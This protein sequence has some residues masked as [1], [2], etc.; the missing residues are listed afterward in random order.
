[1][2]PR[3]LDSAKLQRFRSHMLGVLNAG[4]TA[5]MTSIGHRAGLFDVMSRMRAATSREI[6]IAAGLDER[7]VREWLAA[8]VTGGVVEYGAVEQTYLLPREHAAWLTRRE[9][10]DNLAALCQWIPALGAIEDRVL[11]C[12]ERGGGVPRT[13]YGRFYAMIAEDAV[14]TLLAGL[15]DQILPMA[16]GLPE[17][18][19]RGIDLLDIRCNNGRTLN[20]LAAAF[21]RSRFTGFGTRFQ[22]VECARAEAR[23]A[24]LPNVRFALHD[25]M[26]LDAVDQFDCVT[27]FDAIH[28][29]RNPQAVLRAVAGA[30]RPDGV[31]LLR[32]L[33][34][35]SHLDEDAA[36]PLGAFLY[37]FSCLHGMTVSLAE[38]GPGVGAMW[39]AERALTM[40]AEA[41]FA[42]VTLHQL[43][44]DP[45]SLFFVSRK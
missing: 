37:A 36:N 8:M 12:F 43:P 2:P 3:E 27:A 41:G 5:L 21:P 45:I 30:L 29:H 25:P 7:Y 11:D 33:A 6:A 20:H 24:G 18:L 10:A 23:E 4:A 28:D 1:M 9:R 32:D 44:R 19:E 17:A 22:S 31:F 40:M 13:T 38:R 14:E 35:T 15:L 42:H 34:G 16:P 26:E 39:G